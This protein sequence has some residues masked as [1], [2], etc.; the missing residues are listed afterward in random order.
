[1]NK[2]VL[3][4][5]CTI[6]SDI[7]VEALWAISL[8]F[9]LVSWAMLLLNTIATYIFLQIHFDNF[10]INFRWG[11]VRKGGGLY[12]FGDKWKRYHAHK[13][14]Q[15]YSFRF[16]ILFSAHL[17]ILSIHQSPPLHIINTSVPTFAYYQHISAFC[18]PNK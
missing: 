11:G 1:M 5:Y 17:C 14:L 7:I 8:V 18:Y 13:S 10:Q 2:N 4:Y 6:N 12:W 9:K 15:R 3:K 16:M